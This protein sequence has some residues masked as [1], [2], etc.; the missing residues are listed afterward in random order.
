M[1]AKLGVLTAVIV[2]I[3]VFL[4]VTPCSVVQLYQCSSVLE[5][6][7]TSIIYFD[8]RGSRFPETLVDVYQTIWCLIP[9]DSNLSDM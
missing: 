1:H 2:K 6:P 4:D 3:T 7:A 8:S 5:E 9:E